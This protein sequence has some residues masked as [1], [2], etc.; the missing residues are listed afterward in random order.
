MEKLS[1]K[2]EITYNNEPCGTL[3]T[4]KEGLR[5]S[6][7]A[8]CE[9]K[10][11]GI[12]RLMCLSGGRYI[13]I[14]V[15]LPTGDG[16]ITLRK[17]FTKN[18]L[19]LMQLKSIEKCIITKSTNSP[20]PEDEIIHA[21][22]YSHIAY[23]D[24]DDELFIEAGDWQIETNP[25]ELFADAQLQTITEGIIGA[26]ARETA[27]GVELA[28]PIFSEKPFPMMPVFRHG[29]SEKIGGKEYIIFTLKDGLLYKNGE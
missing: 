17:S 15:M 4:E 19:S 6:F 27:H 1:G 20:E 28:I 8:R 13:P 24:D 18:D 7:D 5:L 10:F 23:D 26:L 21:E 25:H 29:R 11:G 22:G 3:I 14:G 9:D 2:Y 12:L 16:M